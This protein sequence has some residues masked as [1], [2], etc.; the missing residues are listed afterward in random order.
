MLLMLLLTLLT[1]TLYLL[2]YSTCSKWHPDRHASDKKKAEE[3][4]KEIAAAY[5]TLSDPEKR[6]MYDQVR[7]A[8]A[9]LY[10]SAAIG[11]Y[12]VW[13]VCIE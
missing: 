2:M 3:R 9:A 8:A 13:F 6:R 5:E 10:T 11:S 1:Y 12:H 7:A 4:F